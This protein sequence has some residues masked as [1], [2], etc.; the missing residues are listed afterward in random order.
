MATE[1]D[2]I[3]KTVECIKCGHP[4]WFIAGEVDP[5]PCSDCGTVNSREQPD[6]FDAPVAPVAPDPGLRE[7]IAK[8][9]AIHAGGSEHEENFDGWVEQ[10]DGETDAVLAVLAERGIR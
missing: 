2:V 10:F 3:G 9:L 1:F 5:H 6:I 4:V 7:A 8:A